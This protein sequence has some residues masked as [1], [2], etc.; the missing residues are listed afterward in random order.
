MIWKISFNF[1][2]L[3]YKLCDVL[4][5]AYFIGHES[6]SFIIANMQKENKYISS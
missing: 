3:K 1:N 2:L 5:F 4:V 6:L